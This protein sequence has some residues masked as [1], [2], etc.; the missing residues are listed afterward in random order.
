M[1]II[2]IMYIINIIINIIS[3]EKIKADANTFCLYC[4]FNFR[5]KIFLLTGDNFAFD[6]TLYWRKQTCFMAKKVV[7]VIQV[8][9]VHFLLF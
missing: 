7:H 3:T 8:L 1:F 9:F 2:N 6:F 4:Y 5:L